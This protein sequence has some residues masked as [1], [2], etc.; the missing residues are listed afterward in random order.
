MLAL[1]LFREVAGSDANVGDFDDVTPANS[2]LLLLRAIG[3]YSLRQPGV[4]RRSKW[5][6]SGSQTRK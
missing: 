6:P 3:S 1:S 5:L 4:V 2:K